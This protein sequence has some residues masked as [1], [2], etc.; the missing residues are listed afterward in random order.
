LVLMKILCSKDITFV[1]TPLWDKCEDEAHTPKSEKL[2][3]SRTLEN[4]EL[5]YKG[6]NSFHL[7]VLYV[8]ERS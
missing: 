8:M 3:S 5:D 6:Q 4:S 7:I 2:E 1:A